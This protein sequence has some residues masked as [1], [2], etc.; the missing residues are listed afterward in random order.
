MAVPCALRGTLRKENR[1]LAFEVEIGD[2]V[3]F[4]GEE[5]EVTNVIDRDK[6]EE[7]HLE[8]TRWT[9]NDKEVTERFVFDA[10]D[11]IE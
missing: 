3:T 2:H 8:L 1:V 10:N 6:G 11:E 4:R 9:D 7:V 5:W